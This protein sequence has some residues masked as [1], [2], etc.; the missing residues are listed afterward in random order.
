[1]TSNQKL[2][3]LTIE[4]SLKENSKGQKPSTDLGQPF[5]EKLIIN[6]NL[7]VTE[8]VGIVTDKLCLT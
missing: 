4:G 5:D 7:F 6:S 2:L 3:K 1:L 8:L